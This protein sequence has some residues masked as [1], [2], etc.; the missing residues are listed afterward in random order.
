MEF[1]PGSFLCEG[2]SLKTLS[3]IKRRKLVET[4]KEEEWGKWE[5]KF[6]TGNR[7]AAAALLGSS[8]Q[9]QSRPSWVW[10]SSLGSWWRWWCSMKRSFYIFAGET[11]ESLNSKNHSTF[12]SWDIPR[13]RETHTR[14]KEWFT[15]RRLWGTSS[16]LIWMNTHLYL[17]SPPWFYPS[18][19]SF[20]CC[21]SR[22]VQFN[23]Q[24]YWKSEKTIG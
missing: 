7:P 18:T 15:F 1:L 4:G 10:V 9:V 13:R 8:L 17:N 14:R 11:G 16:L 5:R 2:S 23:T 24:S 3:S 12:S 21:F 6:Q 19:F 22:Y 20:P